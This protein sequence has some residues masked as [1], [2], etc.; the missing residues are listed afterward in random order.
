[1]SIKIKVI[2]GEDTYRCPDTISTLSNVNNFIESNFNFESN[3]FKLKYFDDDK[4]EIGIKTDAHLY[5]AINIATKEKRPSLKI[6][7]HRVK[8][9]SKP[10]QQLQQTYPNTNTIATDPLSKL[11]KRRMQ[12]E[13]N[14]L[15]Y[16]QERK[17][18]TNAPKF[19]HNKL[20]TSKLWKISRKN[21]KT[22]QPD[23]AKWNETVIE[24]N[25]GV[26]LDKSFWNKVTIDEEIRFRVD[27]IHQTLS[28]IHTLEQSMSKDTIEI[29]KHYEKSL[30]YKPNK[31][32]LVNTK[33]KNIQKNVQI[34]EK[35]ILKI[36]E[37]K[38]DIDKR[39]QSTLKIAKED[40]SVVTYTKIN[41]SNFFKPTTDTLIKEQ[42]LYNYYCRIVK[43]LD[44]MKRKK[45]EYIDDIKSNTSLWKVINQRAENKLKNN[46][47][48][49][50]PSRDSYWKKKQQTPPPLKP[51]KN[52]KN[53]SKRRNL[54]Q[55][56]CSNNE[57]AETEIE[58]QTMPTIESFFVGNRK[59]K[60]S[61]EF[62]HSD[63]PLKIRKFIE[64]QSDTDDDIPINNSHNTN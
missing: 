45:I 43:K 41:T 3:T 15:E 40:G 10:K 61:N 21:T 18:I 5:E 24:V 49:R 17:P 9:K 47:K 31:N 33:W 27:T 59:R 2:C 64:L 60:R 53:N 32:S 8:E 11:Q 51:K 28:L 4:D 54:Q 42:K 26:D 38:R 52:N 57:K 39:L 22:I 37:L 14:I 25:S 20:I 46:K 13:K 12:Q 16:L 7:I 6:Y 23:T 36:N 48:K 35:I 30:K 19:L 50:K 34:G 62:S 58:S 44:N 1:M 29:V 55:K 56:N 63:Q